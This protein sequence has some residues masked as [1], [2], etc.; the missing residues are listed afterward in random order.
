[1]LIAVLPV[2]DEVVD[3]GAEDWLWAL[4]GFCQRVCVDQRLVSNADH[5]CQPWSLS[6]RTIAIHK[7]AMCLLACLVAAIVHLW[8]EQRDYSFPQLQFAVFLIGSIVLS[9]TMLSFM[10]GASRIQPPEPMVS[11][12]RFVGRHTL[13]I[14]AVQ[15]GASELIIKLWPYLAS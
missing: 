5:A 11:L 13:E 3:Y 1:M 14:C 10:R 15:L 9:L 2:V 7:G 12:L 4:F 8:Y 6:F